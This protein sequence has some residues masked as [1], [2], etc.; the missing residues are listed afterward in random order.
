MVLCIEVCAPIPPQNFHKPSFCVAESILYWHFS[1]KHW[2]E[3]LLKKV[4]VDIK[5]WVGNRD[6]F[7]QLS[8]ISADKRQHGENRAG[9]VT[10]KEFGNIVKEH[11]LYAISWVGREICGRKDETP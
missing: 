7:L 8:F 3:N 9:D 6:Y 2:L 4:S 1:M 5:R 11:K 10:D